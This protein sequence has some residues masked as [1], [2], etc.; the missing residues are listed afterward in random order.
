MQQQQY[1]RADA[2]DSS[3]LSRSV[4][5][6]TVAWHRTWSSIVWSLHNHPNT[7][8]QLA[9]RTVPCKQEK[10]PAQKKGAILVDTPRHQT[11]TVSQHQYF[12]IMLYLSHRSR[13]IGLVSSETFLSEKKGVSI[14]F[15]LSHNS[16]PKKDK[17]SAW[18]LNGLL[19]MFHD[20]KLDSNAR[21]LASKSLTS[22]PDYLVLRFPKV[23]TQLPVPYQQFLPC[24][25]LP[26]S[27]P[28]LKQGRHEQ[29][30]TTRRWSGVINRCD[31]FFLCAFLTE[32]PA[33]DNTQQTTRRSPTGTFAW[34][35]AWHE[36]ALSAAAWGAASGGV[37]SKPTTHVSENHVKAVVNTVGGL[38]ASRRVFCWLPLFFFC[39]YS[40]KKP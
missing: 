31:A 19:C 23:T 12:W 3:A 1:V 15:L 37:N 7:R 38:L 40:S 6:T 39:S 36:R 9:G 22:N 26:H 5:L 11:Q 21:S 4:L 30:P 18:H 27:R 24:P 14:T 2:R 32:A 33:P 10:H 25:P 29:P 28:L 17:S 8:I 34:T 13:L 35:F 20:P 16:R